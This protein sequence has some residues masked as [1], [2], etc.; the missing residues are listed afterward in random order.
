MAFKLHSTLD[1]AQPPFEYYLMTDS[2]AVTL[3]EALVQ[4]SGRLTLC[5]VT[6]TPQFIAQKTQAAETTAI[7]PIPVIRVTEQQEW[8]NT[9]NATTAV[10]LVGNKVTIHSD[11]LV[12]TATTS[13]GVFELTYT[14]AVTDGGVVRG[15]F[16]K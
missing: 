7:T 6:T 11:G 13:S 15:L 1:G 3:G 2:E 14:D 10:T 12:V 4:T 9:S 8:E 16:T 5:G